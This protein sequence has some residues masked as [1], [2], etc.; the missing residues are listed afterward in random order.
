MSSATGRIID[1]TFSVSAET[2]VVVVVV[3]VVELS[4][5]AVVEV[6]VLGWLQQQ[7]GDIALYSYFSGVAQHWF[8]PLSCEV[9][10]QMVSLKMRNQHPESS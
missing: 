7:P 5:V 9:P 10:Q 4:V 2:D 3:V 1:P 6:E 8:H